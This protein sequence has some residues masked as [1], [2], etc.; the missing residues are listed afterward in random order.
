MLN[1]SIYF[2]LGLLPGHHSSA[3]GVNRLTIFNLLHNNV[4][5]S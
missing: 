2:L 5:R 1:L 4:S 3:Y